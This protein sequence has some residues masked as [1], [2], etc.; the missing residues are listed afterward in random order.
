MDHC[1]ETKWEKTA[2]KKGIKG[3]M[4]QSSNKLNCAK[5]KN[6]NISRAM[7]EVP[8]NID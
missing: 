6:P 1:L 8:G 5:I 2:E 7:G 3:Y 4:L